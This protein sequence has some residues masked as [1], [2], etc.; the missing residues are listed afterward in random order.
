MRRAGKSLLRGISLFGL[1]ATLAGCASLTV[2]RVTDANRDSVQGQ[3]YY[4]P[5]PVITVAPQADGTV[6]VVVDYLPDQDHEYA[7]DTQSSFSS[8]AFQVVTDIRGLL[9]GVQYSADTTAVAQQL[10]SGAGAAAVQLANSQSQQLVAEQTLINTAQNNVD[11]DNI[12]VQAAA[13]ALASDQKQAA[14]N[15]SS[16]TPATLAADASALAQANAKLTAAQQVF[17]RTQATAQV[18]AA[19]ATQGTIVSTPA[20]AAGTALPASTWTGPS[21]ISLPNQYGAVTFL[22]NDSYKFDAQGNATGGV[23]LVAQTGP[24]TALRPTGVEQGVNTSAQPVFA[25]TAT[26]LGPPNLLP[27]GQI[28]PLSTKTASFFFDRPP[29]KILSTSVS[30]TAQ[31][32]VLQTATITPS[33]DNKTIAVDISQL[34]PGNYTLSVQFSYTADLRG[35]IQAGVKTQTFAVQ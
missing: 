26:A 13:A 31:P 29:T 33:A 19:G 22:V 28:I 35:T 18:V 21:A 27:P 25:V 15:P 11:T 17:T 10:A 23:S 1:C 24:N 4:L 6:G 2:T 20:A 12:A 5:K 9:T 7:I 8:Y 3:R 32:P 30:S 14:A 16:V 34:K